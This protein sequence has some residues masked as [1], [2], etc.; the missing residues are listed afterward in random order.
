MNLL[1]AI[2]TINTNL[3]LPVMIFGYFL[4]HPIAWSFMMANWDVERI[5][6]FIKRM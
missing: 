2:T 6:I 3:F 4:T 5:N 1:I